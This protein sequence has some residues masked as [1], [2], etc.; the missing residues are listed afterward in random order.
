MTKH[1]HIAENDALLDRP[2][3]GALTTRLAPI[4]KAF[5]ST[6]FMP[7]DISP[8]AASAGSNSKQMRDFAML[9]WH[10]ETPLVTLERDTPFCQNICAPEEMASGLQMIA[11][12]HV[13]VSTD[14]HVENLGANDAD[15][16]YQLA[17]Q[18]KPG[19]FERNTYKMGDFIGIRQEG[20]LV[21]MA[22][23]RLKIPGF[24]EISAVCVAP[25]CRFKGMGAALVRH[26]CNRI[27]NQGDLP[28]LHV[29][30]SNRNAIA[31][32]QHLGFETRARMQATR[33]VRN[34]M[35]QYS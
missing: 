32:Y 18:T 29:Y 27:M 11:T 4:A 19:P 3:W 22:G 31:L 17:R 33:W 30:E 8:M 14:H 26:M 24:T 25:E 34:K 7:Q 28:F 12:G 1:F 9:I 16:M 13:E 2:V 5:G 35:V 20:R 15:D 10:R 23:Q 6:L 21:A